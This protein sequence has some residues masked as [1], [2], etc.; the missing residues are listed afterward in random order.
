[1][2]KTAIK[3]KGPL[4]A[5]QEIIWGFLL[6]FIDEKGYAPTRREIGIHLKYTGAWVVEMVGHH[7]RAMET[8]GYLKLAHDATVRRGI[9]IVTK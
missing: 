2:K 4:S 8:K 7:L 3:R 9:E 6:G 1:M 5:T